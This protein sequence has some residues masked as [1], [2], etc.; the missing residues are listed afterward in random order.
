MSLYSEPFVKQVQKW[1][2]NESLIPLSNPQIAD[3]LGDVQIFKSTIE[4]KKPRG[5]SFICLSISCINF[6]YNSNSVCLNARPLAGVLKKLPCKL[7]Q[8]EELLPHLT[9]GSRV[10]ISDDSSGKS[11]IL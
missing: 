8:V 5:K 3:A 7:N 1:I 2:Q 9:P 11:F 6:F 10:I 4:P